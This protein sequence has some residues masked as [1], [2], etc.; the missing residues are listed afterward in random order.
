MREIQAL[1]VDDSSVMRKI[2]ERSL[3]QAGLESL[4]V[5]EASSGVEGIEAL[6]AVIN[7]PQT[8]Y[9]FYVTDP[10]TGINHYETT[11]EEHVA[12]IQKYGL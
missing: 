5:I 1:I 2:V 9:L 6:K 3:R 12:D 10:K 7:A 8:N 11:G 4:V